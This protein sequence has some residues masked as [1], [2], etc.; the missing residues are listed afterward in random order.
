MRSRRWRSSR[1]SSSVRRRRKPSPLPRSPSFSSSGR[2]DSSMFRLGESNRVLGDAAF[3][4]AAGIVV[5]LILPDSRVVDL[6]TAASIFALYVVSWAVF[7]GPA[8]EVSFGH[9]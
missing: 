2:E 4:L 1:A 6:L 5:V 9:G 8:L 7:C 3:A